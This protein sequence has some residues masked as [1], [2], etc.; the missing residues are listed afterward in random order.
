MERTWSN[1]EGDAGERVS[2]R[3]GWASGCESD[4]GGDGH[5]VSAANRGVVIILLKGV[6][7]DFI[8][9]AMFKLGLQ[10]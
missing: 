8:E 4:R 10:A 2:F 3:T 1:S 6:R 7:E 5:S 9:E